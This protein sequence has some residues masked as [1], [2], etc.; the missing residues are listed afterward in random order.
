MMDAAL[1]P[2][3]VDVPDT[4]SEVFED[5]RL[6]TYSLTIAQADWDTLQKTA[7]QEMFVPAQLSVDGQPIGKVGVRYKGSY[8]LSQCFMD[9]K[10]VCRK[11]SMKLKFDAYDPELRFHGLKRLNLHSALTDHSHL[12]ERVSY[13]LFRE[14]GVLAPRS[15]HGRVLINDRYVGL[16]NVTEEVDGRFTDHHFMG[17]EGDGTLYKEAWPTRSQDPAYFTKAQQTN[18]GAPV[19]KIVAFASELAAAKSD[20]LGGVVA[21]WL[22]ADYTL[23]YLAVHTAIKHWDGPLTF[24]CSAANGCVNHNYFWYESPS[25]NRLTL[26]AWDMDNTFYDNVL[27]DRE[28]V[29]AW[30]EPADECVRDGSSQF[31]APGC[32]RL[33]RGFQ[34][35]G[36]DA[37]RAMLGRLL[38]GPYQVA[39]LQADI[40]RWA[41][42][43]DESVKTD[44]AGSGYEDWK[45]NVANLRKAIATF[46]ERAAAV[47]DGKDP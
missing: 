46:R 1:P 6:R 9:G 37:F 20:A 30:Y 23:R 17:R 39:P 15:V 22:D 33:V 36:H 2:A 10:Q 44:P 3:E 43:I 8:T 34:Q 29:P 18:E 21:R 28:K 19:G 26:I 45:A 40:D 38:E 14:F 47:R 11:V 25:Q 4:S 16:Y 32:D 5:G 31:L 41:K 12:H 13:K 35:L 7:L 24:Y 42:Q 27:T